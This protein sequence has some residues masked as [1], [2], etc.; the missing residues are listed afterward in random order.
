MRGGIICVMALVPYCN[1]STLVPLW[2]NILTVTGTG[3]RYSS[4]G[5]EGAVQVNVVGL[6]LITFKHGFVPTNTSLSNNMGATD[7]PVMVSVER[8]YTPIKDGVTDKM[9]GLGI[10]TSIRNS[11]LT[12]LFKSVVGTSLAKMRTSNPPGPDKGPF[13]KVHFNCPSSGC[14]LPSVIKVRC[15]F[16][17]FLSPIL[18]TNKF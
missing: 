13:S 4:L 11:A 6:T 9:I 1:A 12:P 17:H 7:S 8:P 16:K 5:A 15:T 18:T 10:S 14:S 2:V 3:P